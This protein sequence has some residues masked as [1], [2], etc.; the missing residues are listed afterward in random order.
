MAQEIE[1]P[2]KVQYPHDS[3]CY[4]ITDEIRRGVSAIVYKAI[5]IPMNSTVVAIKS[6]DLEPIS[7]AFVEMPR[8]CHFSLIPTFSE[9]I[10]HSWWIIVFG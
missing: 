1:K 3:T 8:Q 7:K 9:L 5:C 2:T 6:I 10:V 4:K